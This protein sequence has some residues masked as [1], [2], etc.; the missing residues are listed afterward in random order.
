[1]RRLALLVILLYLLTGGAAAQSRPAQV[2]DPPVLSRIEVSPP[3]R[4]GLVTL[5][6]SSGAVFPNAYLGIRNLWTGETVYARAGITGSFTAQITGTRDTPYWISPASVET[7]R[8]LRARPGS[9]PG[10]PGA[11][12]Q[13]P[14]QTDTPPGTVTRLT[15]DGALTDWDAYPDALLPVVGGRTVYALRN[16]DSLTLAL[17]DAP[18]GAAQVEVLLSIDGGNYA[19]L[20]PLN[21][22]MPS[23]R[24]INP[25][26]RD[27]GALRGAGVQANGVFE[28]RIPFGFTDRQDIVQL[29]AVRWLDDAGGEIA[30]QPIATLLPRT[31]AVDAPAL[32]DGFIPLDAPA[33]TIG[34]AAETAGGRAPWT[35]SGRT[36]A[37]RFAPG[38]TWRAGLLVSL[39]S[40]LQLPADANLS[41]QLYLQPVVQQIDGVN[42]PISSANTGNGWS[43]RLTPSGVPID[44][45]FAL[46]ELGAPITVPAET[47]IRRIDETIAFPI[48]WEVALPADLPP[49]IYVPLFQGTFTA[50]GASGR[51]DQP[52]GDATRLPLV[53]TLGD[54]GEVR[55]PMALFADDLSD[56]S[57]GTMPIDGEDGALSNRVRYN[58]PTLILPP[59]TSTIPR[60]PITYAIEPYL[61]NI[62]PN[63]YDVNAV[64]LIPFDLPGGQLVAQ[65]RRPSGV[66]DELGV[67]PLAQNRLS[68]PEYDEAALFGDSSPVDMFR[69]TTLEP[70]FTAY[71]F[72][73][74]G[75]YTITMTATVR[76]VWGNSYSGG[77]EYRVVA[78]EL[79]DLTPGTLPGAPYTVGD[80]F[81]PIVRL[82]PAAP[83]EVTVSIR[84]YPIDGSTPVVQTLSGIADRSGTFMPSQPPLIFQQPGEYVVDY[85][86]RYT[87]PDG[88]LW[89]GSMR[90]AGVVAPASAEGLLAHGERGTSAAA[91]YRPA[92]YDLARY[93][94]VNGF[95][96]ASATLYAPYHSGD[97]VWLA[98]GEN[99]DLSMPLRLSDST[100]SVLPGEDTGFFGNVERGEL[101]IDQEAGYAYVSVTRPNVTVRQSVRRDN[102]LVAL[103]P[104]DNDDALNRQIGA[105]INGNVP[106]DL[107]FLFGGAVV[108]PPQG[109][110]RVAGYAAAG[111]VIAPD[112]S[113]GERVMPPGRGLDGG[114]D[115]GALLT[116]NG[117]AYDMV[118]VPTALQPGDVLRLG[119]P[120]IF[121]GQIA[122]TLPATVRVTYTK[123]SGAV[124][125]VEGTANRF[126]GFFRVGGLQTADEPGV[127][128]ARVE[129][130]YAGRTSAGQITAPGLRGGVIGAADGTFLFAVV[131]ADAEP[132][133]WS[134]ALTDSIIAIGLPYNF[135]FTLP[136][137]WTNIRAT[138]IMTTP[139]YL[140]FSES[141]RVSG[142]SFSYQYIA[143]DVARRFSII[144]RDVRT[145]G[146]H[147]SDVRTLTFIVT[148]NNE[149]GDPIV[150]AR[151][152]T[153]MHDRL[154]TLR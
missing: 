55:L 41:A 75:E 89:A 108:R 39:N 48:V 8:E 72:R 44:G 79:L 33:F 122:P 19:A 76:D 40:A 23:L 92:W 91:S 143:A 137:G 65:V 17:D 36:G 16:A 100:R 120:F 30:D 5:T 148:A 103:I 93:A 118:I 28:A 123:P 151:T 109:E 15:L 77:G 66:V 107:L 105:G 101:R 51:W 140:L 52:E 18:S 115:G 112:A 12:L 154:V 80:V 111:V 96:P 35:A 43:S 85:E 37:L 68:T 56:G 110:S 87:A 144:E 10:G 90:G 25:N 82:S 126:G 113:P 61:P 4:F 63:R 49:G 38:E 60:R 149:T 2:G 26:Q 128:T 95:R 32:P 145:P 46:L 139:G 62:L 73:E 114:A 129:V 84:F 70:R 153:L 117:V 132:L 142:R 88:S 47:I 102:S 99:G 134:A 3:N 97:V 125:T 45:G 53:I 34:G 22:G 7:P 20:F 135:N 11:I 64:P 57:R 146:S 13:L 58:A 71:T 150:R 59:F 106:D 86:A 1:M 127:W 141:L 14:P 9:M 78:A 121:S 147:V 130:S 94:E 136:N 69:L 50:T 83:A 152:F 42:V 67:A 74:Y 29:D 21:G 133:P 27:F 104:W 54:P 31:D 131:P 6:G 24:R 119:E 138:A 98:D 124:V 81:N 116:F